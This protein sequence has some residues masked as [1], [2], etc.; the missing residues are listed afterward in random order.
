MW[1]VAVANNE[2]CGGKQLRHNV[3]CVCVCVCVLVIHQTNNQGAAV[4]CM[5]WS[6]CS[7]AS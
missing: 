6:A 7:H 3:V 4:L 1:K 5:N 2:P